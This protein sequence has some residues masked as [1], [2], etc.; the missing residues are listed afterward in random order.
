LILTCIPALQTGH[1]VVTWVVRRDLL[2][3][4]GVIVG[5]LGILLGD[6]L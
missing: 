6:A 5:L 2:L 3:Y 1:G 4:V